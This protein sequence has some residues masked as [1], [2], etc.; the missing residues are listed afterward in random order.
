[1]LYSKYLGAKKVNDWISPT[2]EVC[3]MV[4]G[5]GENM[6]S[7]TVWGHT[8]FLRTVLITEA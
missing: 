3:R 4:R 5:K 2:L 1:M 6:R 7:L 8:P